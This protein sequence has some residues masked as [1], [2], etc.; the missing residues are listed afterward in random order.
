MSQQ[1]PKKKKRRERN[2]LETILPQDT[3]LCTV[4]STFKR[5]D[6]V[7]KS[8]MIE[9]APTEM[10]SGPS[11]RIINLLN[12]DG[13]TGRHD[14]SDTFTFKTSK[15][16]RTNQT[17]E[18]Q[19]AEEESRKLAKYKERLKTCPLSN[20]F[21]LQKHP[22]P[23]QRKCYANENRYLLPHPLI[24]VHSSSQSL[25]WWRVTALLAAKDGEALDKYSTGREYH[26]LV[27]PSGLKRMNRP[28][29]ISCEFSLRLLSQSALRKFTLIFYIKYMTDAGKISREKVVSEPFELQSNKIF[30]GA[31]PQVETVTPWQGSHT[32]TTEVT[33]KGSD[34]SR[35]VSVHLDGKEIPVIRLANTFVVVQVPAQPTLQATTTMQLLLINHFKKQKVAA[36]STQEFT[37]IV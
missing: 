23:F 27:D 37:Y 9:D 8:E 20:N 15:P 1:S 34:F 12:G 21:Y 5:S 28:M 19:T 16:P 24:I 4:L 33:I 31:E 6:G 30:V 17:I 26:Y 18:S 25:Q 3:E 29:D 10:Q 11:G 22:N 35:K 7:K 13:D 36:R 32:S 2:N 14:W